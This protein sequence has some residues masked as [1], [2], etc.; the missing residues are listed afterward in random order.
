MKCTRNP[1]QAQMVM[2]GGGQAVIAIAPPVNPG[3]W[4]GEYSIAPSTLVA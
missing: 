2:M 4:C 1:P 3:E